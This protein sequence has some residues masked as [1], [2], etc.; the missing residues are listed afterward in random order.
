MSRLLPSG[1]GIDL[2]VECWQYHRRAPTVEQMP[3]IRDITAAVSRLF[4]SSQRME[5]G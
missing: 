1:L 5:Q 2:H 3:I 4:G